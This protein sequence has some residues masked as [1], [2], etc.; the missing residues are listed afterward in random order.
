M[1]M[2]PPDASLAK[3]RKELDFAFKKKQ[4]EIERT[5]KENEDLQLAIDAENDDISEDEK[6]LQRSEALTADVN[7]ETETFETDLET[8]HLQVLE[9]EQILSV[10]NSQIA[11]E[12]E[13][14][15]KE[16]EKLSEERLEFHKSQARMLARLHLDPEDIET[17]LQSDCGNLERKIANTNNA[18]FPSANLDEELGRLQEEIFDAE[19]Q[20]E[21]PKTSNI[22]DVNRANEDIAELQEWSP[23]KHQMQYEN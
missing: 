20:V 1:M 14:S 7:S 2:S 9:L 17:Y 4:E 15:E 11:K 18:N 8:F 6:I 3:S 22:N 5:N 21:T 10:E 16:I 23:A 13:S 19:Q 12:K